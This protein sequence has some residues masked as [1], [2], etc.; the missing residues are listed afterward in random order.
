MI[1]IL[2]IRRHSELALQFTVATSVIGRVLTS[3][4]VSLAVFIRV[5]GWVGDRCASIAEGETKARYCVMDYGSDSDTS[6]YW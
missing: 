2:Y 5:S 4:L 3:S 6:V 1:S